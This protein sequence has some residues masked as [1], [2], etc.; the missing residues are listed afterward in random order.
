MIAKFTRT[1]EEDEGIGRDDDKVIVHENDN[2]AIENVNETNDENEDSR[3]Q[4][5]L[6]TCLLLRFIWIQPETLEFVSI[7]IVAQV[8]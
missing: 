5:K 7:R 2:E 4:F 3:I 1:T 6:I 8:T